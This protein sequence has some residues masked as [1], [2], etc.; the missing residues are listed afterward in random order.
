VHPA[1]IVACHEK[2][3]MSER[4]HTRLLLRLGI[5]DARIEIDTQWR[6]KLSGDAL[7]KLIWGLNPQEATN[8]IGVDAQRFVGSNPGCNVV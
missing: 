3:R 8:E 6:R 1:A 7:H 2:L 4:L 5:G